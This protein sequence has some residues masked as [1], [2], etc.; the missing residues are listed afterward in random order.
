MLW[1]SLQNWWFWFKIN[2]LKDP[3]VVKGPI[4]RVWKPMATGVVT[5]DVSSPLDISSIWEPFNSCI[6]VELIKRSTQKNGFHQM[7][8]VLWNTAE[9]CRCFFRLGGLDLA[10]WLACPP[11]ARSLYLFSQF[12]TLVCFKCYKR[13]WNGDSEMVNKNLYCQST[14]KV[15]LALPIT[16]L[17]SN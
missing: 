17:N 12:P 13:S 7:R 3:I 11:K 14:F 15:E 5:D 1:A 2:L 8:I 9:I 10:G 16:I 4:I 6:K